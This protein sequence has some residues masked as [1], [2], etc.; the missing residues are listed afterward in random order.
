MHRITA[1][2]AGPAQVAVADD[3][4][5]LT[6][7]SK[8]F[9]LSQ[10]TIVSSV[11]TEPNSYLIRP[12]TAKFV[13]SN[14]DCWTNESLKGN[15]KSFIGAYNYVNHVQEPEKSVGFLADAVLRRV[16]IDPSQNLFVYYCDLLVATHRRANPELTKN[17]LLGKVEF[18]S[19]GCSAFF[20]TCSACGQ[21]VV[22]EFDMCDHLLNQK[23]RYF[24]DA[25]GIKRV[26][27]E[28]LGTAQPGTVEFTE[29][30]WLTE[31]PAFA[32]ATKR[33][34]LPLGDDQVVQ[35]TMDKNAAAKDAVQRWLD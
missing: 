22:E 2:V 3:K 15:Y 31:P 16:S 24:I 27:A 35:V 7:K 21:K 4:V 23:G 30:S 32:G 11:V 26:T 6:L 8:D 20:G 17:L 5:Q 14:G 25:R 18:L 33:N 28:I 9:L 29:A 1:A 12:Q 34:F 19:M 10:V 13:N